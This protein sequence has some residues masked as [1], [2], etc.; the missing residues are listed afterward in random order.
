[1]AQTIA[2][3]NQAALCATV[4]A[5]RYYLIRLKPDFAKHNPNSFRSVQRNCY[6]GAQCGAECEAGPEWDSSSAR[7]LL[8]HTG[9]LFSSEVDEF[10]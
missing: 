3:G 9:R 6:S 10:E 4:V 5:P 1:M 8:A 7:E 2:S